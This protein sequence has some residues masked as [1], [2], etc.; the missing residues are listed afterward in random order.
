MGAARRARGVVPHAR[1]AVRV[2]GRR[3]H[4]IVDDGAGVRGVLRLPQRGGVLQGLLLLEPVFLRGSV[5]GKHIREAFMGYWGWGGGRLK[6]I[7]AWGRAPRKLYR[8]SG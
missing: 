3:E 4:P 1:V 5:A 2:L 8:G 6:E 7:G